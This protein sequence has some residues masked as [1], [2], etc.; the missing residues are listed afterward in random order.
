MGLTGHILDVEVALRRVPSPWIA[1][2]TEYVP[3]LETLIARCSRPA[4]RGRTR[5][6]GWT[7]SAPAAA[8]AASSIAAA[9][10]SRTRPA[11]GRWCGRARSPFRWRA[12]YWALSP[13][14][15]RWFN[16][17]VL[18]SLRPRA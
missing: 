17:A 9:G 18:M 8:A 14:G 6:R 10:P 15:M 12:P 3:D 13:F 7:R 2:E 16:E 11:A 4:G 5:W 1:G